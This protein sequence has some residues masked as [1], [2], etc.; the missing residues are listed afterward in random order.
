MKYFIIKENN[1]SDEVVLYS[2]DEEELEY[3]VKEIIVNFIAKKILGILVSKISENFISQLP[4]SNSYIDSDFLFHIDSEPIDFML[5]I[6]KETDSPDF[7]IKF[8]ING[9]CV[10]SKDNMILND[11][12]EKYLSQCIYDFINKNYK[13]VSINYNLTYSKAQE[14]NNY[15]YYEVNL[16]NLF[17][18]GF[19]EE[20]TEKEYKQYYITNT[21]K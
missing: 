16:D 21:F 11:D 10:L 14:R 1:N 3:K 18:I 5:V 19:I 7:Q 9:E 20:I 6:I 4:F 13:K 2:N 8:L 17:E 15:F 12:M